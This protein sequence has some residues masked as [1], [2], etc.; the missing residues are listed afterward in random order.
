MDLVPVA[1]SAFAERSTGGFYIDFVVKRAEAARLGLGGADGNAVVA[2]AT[3]GE[4]IAETVEGRE[5]YPIAAAGTRVSLGGPTIPR[6]LPRWPQRRLQ[7]GLPMLVAASEAAAGSTCPAR[8][9]VAR[10]SRRPLV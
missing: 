7:R 9:P 1:R 10:A 3:G 2:Q 6:R 5:R 8:V 4:N